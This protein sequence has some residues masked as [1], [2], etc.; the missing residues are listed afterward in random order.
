MGEVEYKETTAYKIQTVP[1]D[2]C[3]YSRIITLVSKE[4]FLPLVRDFYDITGTLWK[5]QLFEEITVI[6]GIPTPLWITMNNVQTK[7][8]TEYRVSEVC[9]GAGLPDEVFQPKG[10]PNALLYDFCPLP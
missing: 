1:E 8:S 10:L 5:R 2:R 6:N 7:T 3:Y 4:T 9:Y